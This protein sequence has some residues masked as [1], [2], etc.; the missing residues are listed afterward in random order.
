MDPQRLLDGTE[1]VVHRIQR[2]VRVLEDRLH[3]PAELEELLAFQAGSVHAVEDDLA[4][5]GALQ[6][7]DHLCNRGLARTGL[8]N[9][10][11]GG[12][13]L[14]VEAHAVDG[15]KVRGL[16]Q[17]L[18]E[19]VDL[20]EV[21]DLEDIVLCTE[22]SGRGGC[23]QVS[24]LDALLLG[25]LDAA[26]GQRRSRLHQ[27]LGVRVLR[28][29]EQ[30]K[31]RP[32]LNHVALV[33]HNHLVGAL[34]GQAEIVRDEQHGRAQLGGHLVQVVEDLPLHGNV[35]G[36]CG[37]IG[38]QQLWLT[39]E[40]DR[41]QGTLTHTTGELVRILLGPPGSIGKTRFRQR[42]RNIFRTVRAAVGLEGFPDLIPDFPHRVQV[43][44]GVLRDHADV[45]AAEF[46]HPLLRRMGDVLA[47]EQDLSRR[48]AP[49]VRQQ[50]D[51]GQRR[52]RLSRTG[53]PHNGDGL[54]GPSLHRSRS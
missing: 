2:T 4:L 43:G 6:L 39:T 50:T 10:R 33:H 48:D 17:P 41:D 36:R 53:L 49:V 26:R 12:A 19:L 51:G 24:R 30:F 35:Q 22:F 45:A 3:P 11:G 42:P 52:R 44:H 13:T 1:D 28:V 15:G 5:G 32:G 7:K 31:G 40:A 14:D 38:N 21:A 18:A 34:C 20:A 54:A 46:D 25:H 29:A 23:Q 37:L 8:A 27:A 9:N 47:V 16:A